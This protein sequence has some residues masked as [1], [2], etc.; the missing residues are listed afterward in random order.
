MLDAA[1]AIARASSRRVANQSVHRLEMAQMAK[2][3]CRLA[4]IRCQTA[5]MSESRRAQRYSVIAVAPAAACGTSLIVLPPSLV[6]RRLSGGTPPRRA[7]TV[8]MTA[9]L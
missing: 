4:A 8:H 6:T 7:C 1:G 9:G 5:A 2:R 3:G